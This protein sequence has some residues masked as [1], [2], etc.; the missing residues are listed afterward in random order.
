MMTRGI[1]GIDATTPITTMSPR[2]SRRPSWA[3]LPYPDLVEERERAGVPLE[4]GPDEVA[5]RRLGLALDGRREAEL[6]DRLD[7]ERW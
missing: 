1:N 4:G 3:S 5:Q 7:I 6:G 2:T